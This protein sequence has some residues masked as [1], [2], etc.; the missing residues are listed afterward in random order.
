MSVEDRCGWGFVRRVAAPCSM[1]CFK[2]FTNPENLQREHVAATRQMKTALPS[3]Y[4]H[5][6]ATWQL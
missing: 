2:A 6:A 5:I 3:F 4:Q 1:G